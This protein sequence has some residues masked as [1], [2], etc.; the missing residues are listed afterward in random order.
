[1]R[2]RLSRMRARSTDNIARGRVSVVGRNINRRN[3]NGLFS[4]HSL[5]DE[6]KPLPCPSRER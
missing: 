1:M 3:K 4:R 2:F 5:P 6:E